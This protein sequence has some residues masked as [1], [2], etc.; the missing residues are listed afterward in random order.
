MRPPKNTEISDIERDVREPFTIA[1]RRSIPSP[2]D[3]KKK[4]RLLV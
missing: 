2:L 4:H 1:D 3:P